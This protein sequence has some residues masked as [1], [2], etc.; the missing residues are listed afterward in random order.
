[1]PRMLVAKEPSVA[2]FAEYE[3]RPIQPDEI[4]CKVLYAAP[5]H[6]TELGDF[7][8]K[9]IHATER[10]DE[11]WQLFLPRPEGEHGIPFGKWNLGTQWVGRVLEVGAEVKDFGVGDLA[12]SYGGIRETHIVKAVDNYRCR[13]MEDI[14]LWKSA[15]CYD[16][17]RFALGGV[18]D[19][20][21]RPGDAVA[22]YGMGAIGLLA[23]QL[24]VKLGAYPVIAI[25]PIEHRRQIARKQGAHY[26]FDPTGG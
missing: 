19:S 24:C 18:R 1:M 5:K 2:A 25:D 3:D 17:A 22:I 14:S 21:V 26:V 16:P 12:C 9:S 11:E 20:H 15:L 7:K 23:A 13:K 10:F 6:G 8:S 4:R